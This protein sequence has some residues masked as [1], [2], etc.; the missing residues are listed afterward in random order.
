MRKTILTTALIFASAHALA[1]VD[2]NSPTVMSNFN[3]D[4]VEARIGISPTTYGTAI[5]KSI[6]PNA[7]VIARVDSEFDS[8]FDLAT[9]FGFH[10]PINNWADFT[11]EMLFR[12]QDKKHQGSA[13][14]GM[15]VNLGV[16]QWLGPQFEVGG[17]GGYVSI[18]DNDDWFG[19]VYARFH[20]TELFS[21]GVEGRFNDAYGDQVMFT[22]RFNY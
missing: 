10:A 2:P 21:L 15:E 1:Q 5:S 8:D 9:G 3:Y 17:K 14:A 13:D 12:L 16:R 18:D 19:T 22:T 4:Y 6:H 11:G 20:S 7:H